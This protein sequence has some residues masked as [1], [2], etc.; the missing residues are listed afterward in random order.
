[1][2][3]YGSGGEPATPG[4]PGADPELI[5]ADLAPVPPERR[6]WGVYHMASLWVGLSV[7]VPTYMLAAGLVEGGM[8]WWQALGTILAG[9][10]LVLVPLVLIAHPG[11]RYGIPFPVLARAAFGTTG[12]HVPALLRALVACGWFGIQTWIGGAAIDRMLTAVWGGWA[13]VPGGAWIAFFA[14]WVAN[15]WVVVRG[16]E[17]IKRLEAWAAPFLLLS[18]LALL[19]WAV[20]K[21]GGMG[22]ILDQPSRF[23]SRREALAFFVPALTANVGFWATVALN[24]P[25]LSRYARNQRAQAVGQIVGLPATM[26]LFSFTGIAV[27]SACYLVFG[28]AI[29]DP[30]ELVSRLGRPWVVLVSLFALVLATLTTNVAANVVA[31]ANAFSNLA[32]RR[33]DFA[34]GGVLTGVIGIAIMPWRLLESYGTF[35][36]G[37]LVGYSGFLGP[38]AA[39]L[40]AD[41]WVV[42]RTRLEVAE[43]Y[44]RDGRYPR[45]NPAALV[46]LGAGVVVALA[47][48]VVPPLRPLYDYSWFVGFAVAFALYLLLMRGRG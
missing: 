8:A 1:M 25:D 22:P 7:C 28:E 14:F 26:V 11:T 43:L 32:P 21:A 9:N 4:V 47:G 29:W 31:P 16:S 6:T 12:A 15:L 19:G 42:R 2:A 13:S 40:I 36:F 23:A 27:T 37:W 48:L 3:H 41:Y 17:A 46:A 38:V 44:R 33:L 45:F 30:V 24:I 39:I 35:I 18:G 5:N 10:L 34:R 20:V